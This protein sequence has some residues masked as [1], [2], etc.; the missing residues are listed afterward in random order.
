MDISNKKELL[1]SALIQ[2]FVDS[3][4]IYMN[5]INFINSDLELY[6]INFKYTYDNFCIDFLNYALSNIEKNDIFNET[7]I[8][9]FYYKFCQ[10]NLKIFE[11][12]LNEKID[13]YRK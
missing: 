9:N 10:F 12:M 6:N 8:D 2:S 3:H 1:K 5:A 7:N 11:D 4:D 13:N